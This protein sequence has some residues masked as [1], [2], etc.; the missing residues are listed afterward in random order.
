MK[1][2]TFRGKRWRIHD[3]LPAEHVPL[4]GWKGSCDGPPGAPDR[5]MVIPKG[6]DTL[7]DLI[8]ILHESHHACQW[9][10]SEDCVHETSTD[11]ARLLWRLNW[12]K[13]Q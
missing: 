11:Q 1:T 12:R 13:E 5:E 2:H 6:G 4:D 3:T 8:T 9:D 7:E 10:C